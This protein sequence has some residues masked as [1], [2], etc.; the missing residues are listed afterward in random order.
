MFMIKKIP[1]NINMLHHLHID[2]K[3]PLYTNKRHLMT[4]ITVIFG[5]MRGMTQIFNSSECLLNMGMPSQFYDR[6]DIIKD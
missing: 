4:Q 5:G 3:A 2:C 1:Q 6:N